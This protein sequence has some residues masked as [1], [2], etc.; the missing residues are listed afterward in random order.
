MN[1]AVTLE[2]IEAALAALNLTVDEFRVMVNR[3][4]ERSASI[5]TP[6]KALATSQMDQWDERKVPMELLKK[7][8]TTKLGKGRNWVPQP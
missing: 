8:I 3:N 1:N 7:P 6:I 2:Q 4:P 5:K